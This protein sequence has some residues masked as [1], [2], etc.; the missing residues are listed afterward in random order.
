TA[1]QAELAA[2]ATKAGRLFG[3]KDVAVPVYLFA[4]PD[5]TSIGGGY[6]GG[7]LTLEGPRQRDAFP[8]F[9]HQGFHTFLD[10][11]VADSSP[12][13]AT[14]PG[15]DAQTLNEGLAYALSPGLLHTGGKDADPLAGRVR[16]DIGKPF[17]D[18]YTRY[19]RYGLALRPLVKAAL[20]DEK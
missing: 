4:N 2:F 20:D 5:E 9:Q 18:S 17:T 3:V 12:A 11:R 7:V 13:A 15:L 16:A 10:R 8:S 6:N 1:R 14:A 19:N